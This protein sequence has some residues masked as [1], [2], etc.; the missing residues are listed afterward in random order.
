MIKWELR[1]LINVITALSAAAL[2][3]GW[4]FVCKLLFVGEYEGI[5]GA[6]YRNYIA[7]LSDLSF[8]EQS[9]FIEKEDAKIA[10]TLSAE[11]EMRDKYFLGEISDDDYLDYLDRLESCKA[12]SETFAYIKHK[13]TRIC[14]DPRLKF[15]YDLE[16]EGHL[17]TMT[18]DFPLIIM[19]LIFGCFVIIPEIPTES[20]ILTCKNGRR[21]TFAA[22]L[23][24]YFI[25]CG[26]MIAAF[27][28]AELSALFSKNL[29]DL[30]APA[31][32]MEA[33]EELDRDITSLGL[34]VRIFAFRLL[35][36]ITI[37]AMFFALSSLCRNHIAYFCSA[38][39]LV[40]IPAFFASFIPKFLRGVT[41][42]YTLSGKSI[43]IEKTELAVIFGATAWIAASFI[44]AKS[45]SRMNAD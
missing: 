41:V 2:C 17:T 13:Y 7:E 37:C 27:N 22:K 29:G 23:A 36:E 5:N 19:L 12:K 6:I 39:S 3:V 45:K 16:L 32:S 26:V 31:A 1:K 8:G 9:E 18:A 20:F 33:F 24:A 40:M 14:E 35:G 11:T 28:F 25:V 34:I 30:N 4:F 21:K 42:F 10:E 44:T 38:V 15:T 43:P